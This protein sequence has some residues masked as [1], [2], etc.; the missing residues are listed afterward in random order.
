MSPDR[1]RP[2]VALAVLVAV[3]AG[4]AVLATRTVPHPIGPARTLGKYEG[5][6]ATT[7]QSAL[8]AAATVRLAALTASRDRSFGPY[9]TVVIT[10]AEDDLGGVQ[11]TF[12][13]IQPPGDAADDLQ[14]ELD[15]LLSDALD[16][17]RDVRVAARRGELTKLA[18]IA[19]ALEDDTAKLS[20]FHEKHA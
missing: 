8:S 12:D 13:S 4:L 10:D 19:K 16:H 3:L 7:A 20:D 17:V 6:A 14:Q 9:I 11:S 15:Q 18:E 1:R 5:K 2:G